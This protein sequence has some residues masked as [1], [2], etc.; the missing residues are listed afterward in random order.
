MI[1]NVFV[2][3]LPAKIDPAFNQKPADC[4]DSR[5]LR[6]KGTIRVLILVHT[7]DLGDVLF[8]Q[9]ARPFLPLSRGICFPMHKDASKSAGNMSNLSPEF[10]LDIH[11]ESFDCLVLSSP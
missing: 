10:S 5:L 2:Q 1:A 4:D 8:N 11:A 6:G 3:R 9:F 7:K